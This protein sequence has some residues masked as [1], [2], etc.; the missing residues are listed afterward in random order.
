MTSDFQ[1]RHAVRILLVDELNRL[2][3]FKMMDPAKPKEFFWCPVGGG[4]ESGESAVKAAR[5][6][7]A[8]ETGM[9][10]LDLGPHIWN[11]QAKY[12]FNGNKV[13]SIETW[14]LARV[15]NF[16]ID[17]SKF[18][19]LEREVILDHRWWSSEELLTTQDLLTPRNLP[20]LFR[21]LLVNGSPKV[22]IQLELEDHF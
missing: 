11:R 20:S 22:P 6:E 4:I 2:F 9:P 1:I 3:L 17:T 10:D 8:E 13:N 12:S 21:E 19:D 18:S 7:V 16:E 5:R 15:K 14:F